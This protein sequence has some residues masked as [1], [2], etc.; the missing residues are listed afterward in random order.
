M[1]S[2]EAPVRVTAAPRRPRPMPSSSS[3]TATTP[4]STSRTAST[5]QRRSTLLLS[6]STRQLGKVSSRCCWMPAQTQGASRATQTGFMA[7]PRHAGP[8]L[9]LSVRTLVQPQG[10]PRPQSTGLP[11]PGPVRRRQGDPARDSRRALGANNGRRE[12]QRRPRQRRRRWRAWQRER[13]GL[14]VSGLGAVRVDWGDGRGVVYHY[15]CMTYCNRSSACRMMRDLASERDRNNRIYR[16]IVRGSLRRGEGTCTANDAATHEHTAHVAVVTL[17][18][19][20]SA[21]E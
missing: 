21:D 7:L 13:F 18:A 20:E 11:A 1:H 3:S 10:R 15:A 12:Q 2:A 14:S 17:I 5:A 8:L 16:N 9:I 19:R 6:S 4:T